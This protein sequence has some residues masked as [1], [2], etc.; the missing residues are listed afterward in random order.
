MTSI[1]HTIY[2][3]CILSFQ[4]ASGCY[5]IDPFVTDRQRLFHLKLKRPSQYYDTF[6]FSLKYISWIG[7]GTVEFG[8]HQ[9]F[10]FS[11]SLFSTFI[12]LCSCD[13]WVFSLQTF[14]DLFLYKSHE[15]RS[16]AFFVVCVFQVF[17]FLF[18]IF[19]PFLWILLRSKF[20]T[21]QCLGFLQ[22]HFK[23]LDP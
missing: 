6:F 4:T 23:Y 19:L 20:K 8:K 3:L 15:D 21:L 5:N 10:S 22:G 1:R 17:C 7:T 9:F 2:L 11:L 16:W 14:A 12:S 13:S 18:C